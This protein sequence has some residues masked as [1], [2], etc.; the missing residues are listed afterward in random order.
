MKIRTI[1]FAGLVAGSLDAAAACIV[2]LA[3]GRLPGRVFQ[4]I[5][6]AVLGKSAFAEGMTTVAVGLAFH[7]LIALGWAALFF[8]IFSKINAP[9]RQRVVIGL[10]YGV[11][12]WI[13]MNL[14][15][16]PMSLIG[17]FPSDWT[18]I[19]LNMGILM[20]CIGLPISLIFF[21][22]EQTDKP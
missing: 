14:V 12:V 16:V 4:Y 13:M 3:Y 20:V 17:K 7:Y 11:F 10:L 8:F 9:S 22:K 1:L 19:L 6:S 2:A 21:S 5:A 18:N 15:V